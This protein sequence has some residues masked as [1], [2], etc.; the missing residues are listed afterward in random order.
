MKIISHFDSS[1]MNREER[2]ENRFSFL[3][4]RYFSRWFKNICI[5]LTN[6]IRR[7]HSI[8]WDK[9][10]KSFETWNIDRLVDF[11]SSLFELM[12][13]FSVKLNECCKDYCG[14]KIL[15]TSW[16]KLILKINCW[17]CS[18]TLDWNIECCVKFNLKHSMQLAQHKQHI[19][20]TFSCVVDW[21]VSEE[22]EIKS[23]TTDFQTPV[24]C[25]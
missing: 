2:L 24:F 22:G 19:Y 15:V 3:L 25:K 14:I 20:G 23:F 7:N 21:K 13:S 1:I 6:K 16:R 4:L 10:N 9:G 8:E 17:F 12:K 11:A 5:R 18:K